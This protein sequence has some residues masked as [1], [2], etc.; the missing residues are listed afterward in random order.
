MEYRPLGNSGLQVSVAGLGTNNFGGRC[1]YEQSKTVV[2]KALDVG[3]NFIDT[4]DVYG[5]RGLSE[6]F[7]GKAIEGHRRDVL[8]ATKFSSRMGDGPQWA[9]TSRGYI[10]DAVQAS[11]KRLN[12]DYID[13]YQVHFPDAGTP[14]EETMRALDDLVRR[15][16]VRYIGCSNFFA[17]QAVEAQWVAKSEHLTPFISAQNQYNLLDRSIER[18]LAPVSQKY[19][20][21]ILPF[22]PL[23]SGFLTGKYQPGQPPPEGARLSNPQQA[24]RRLTDDNFAKLAP[25]E[26]FAQERDH[27]VGELAMAWLASQPFVGSVIAGAT[28]PEQVEENAR[29]IEWRLTPDDMKALDEAMGV[30]PTGARGGGMPRN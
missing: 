24:A 16:D 21:S 18:D 4:A 10:M 7:I 22:F 26:A 23:A 12:T 27:T 1:D 3:V 20:M 19:G 5:N 17:W 28:K 6:E 15:G 9:G 13:L 14:I 25:L 8:L 11:L 2:H 30:E 29:A